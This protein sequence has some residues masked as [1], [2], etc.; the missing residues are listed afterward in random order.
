MVKHPKKELNR[1][2]WLGTTGLLPGEKPPRYSLHS[3]PLQGSIKH[4]GSL[5][6]NCLIIDIF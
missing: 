6:S 1:S 3:S 5:F 4:T 2:L